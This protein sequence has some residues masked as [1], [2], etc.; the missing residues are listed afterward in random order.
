LNKRGNTKKQIINAAIKQFAKVGYNRTH[1]ESVLK[2]AKIGKGTFYIYFKKSR[3]ISLLPCWKNYF[4]MGKNLSW[5]TAMKM[6]DTMMR[7][8]TEM[9]LNAALFFLK[10][11][12]DICNIYPCIAPGFNEFFEPYI[13]KFESKILRNVTNLLNKGVEVGFYRND[14]DI[15]L[16]P[17]FLSALI[18][19]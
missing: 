12:K 10:K 18:C 3:K 7:I 4:W 16:M 17:I 15:N 2:E 19:G 11:N 8:I 5:L 13:E 6:Q 14:F 1:I 9:Y